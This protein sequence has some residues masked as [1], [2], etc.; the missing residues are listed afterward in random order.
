MFN[1]ALIELQ[2]KSQAK[3]KIVIM[4]RFTNFIKLLNITT[5]PIVVLIFLACLP[6][7][8]E[9]IAPPVADPYIRQDKI[10]G[11]IR[12]ALAYLERHGDATPAPRAA[13]DLLMLAE[14]FD[15]AALA[16]S[17]KTFILFRHSLS[18]QGIH[19]LG[20]FKDSAAFSDFVLEQAEK[21]MRRDPAAFPLR[22]TRLNQSGLS[23][24]G[25][26]LLDDSRFLLC[27][28]YFA[29]A[30]GA[31]DMRN[32]LRSAIEQQMPTD[33][34]LAA[35]FSILSDD[36]AAPKDKIIRLHAQ[37]NAVP[38]LTAYSLE[39]LSASDRGHPAV[40][41][42]LI[43]NAIEDSEFEQA[44]QALDA[45]PETDRST[46]QMLFWKARI[47]L[48]LDQGGRAADILAELAARHPESP[49]T[50]VAGRYRKGID[51]MDSFKKDN[52][53][54]ILKAIK[55][56]KTDIGFFEAGAHLRTAADDGTSVRH[57]IYVG[58]LPGENYLE[59]S[60]HKNQAMVLGYRTAKSQSSLYF[61]GRRQIYTYDQ[62]AV[63]PVPLVSLTKAEN[64]S[65]VF[66][67]GLE[68]SASVQQ[69]GSRIADLFNSP[70]L[71]TTDGI[72]AL[73]AHTISRL[74]WVPA[75]PQTQNGATTFIWLAPDLD[76]PR[77][78]RISYTLSADDR[79]TSIAGEHFRIAPLRYG[80]AASRELAPPAWPDLPRRR[81]ARFDGAVW[82]E[83]MG[84]VM[85]H[86]GRDP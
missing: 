33:D 31:T 25:R 66:Q 27:A 44:L 30:A 49:W 45:L 83:F 54:A 8:A 55:R 76:A 24:F 6:V 35:H 79:I 59:F 4:K 75:A 2:L 74:G 46:P 61:S 64:G 22:F 13:L 9:E 20:T 15:N 1:Y 40:R 16:T 60:W 14:R 38:L 48:A 62:P 42:I 39:T 23:H 47:L 86:L 68:F 29:G 21:E 26:T 34:R 52:A 3:M 19:L 7:Q 57:L 51:R 56:L 73:L 43:R 36:N 18:L 28:W 12:E 17:M 78:E 37:E 82:F 71:S 63:V 69:A 50:P 11:Y 85:T 80:P 58:L 10:Q 84:A 72:A 81:S 5:V 67:A 77:L 41:R 32:A 53:D 70:Y 65:F